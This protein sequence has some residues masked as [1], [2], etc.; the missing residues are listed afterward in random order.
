MPAQFAWKDTPKSL[1]ADGIITVTGE[2][3]Q[4]LLL[5]SQT[6]GNMT[7][8]NQILRNAQIETMPDGSYWLRTNLGQNQLNGNRLIPSRID[9]NKFIQMGSVRNRN[10]ELDKLSKN[11]L[12]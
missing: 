5:M 3:A 4:N 8:G 10:T 9:I 11:D 6:S 7:G 12:I 1:D 2:V